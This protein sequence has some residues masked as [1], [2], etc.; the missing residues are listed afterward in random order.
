MDEYAEASLV[1]WR[2]WGPDAIEE[3]QAQGKPILLSLSARWCSWC[4]ELDETTFTRPTIAA[5]LNE[6]FVPIRVDADRQPR[7][8]ERY[9]VGGFPSVVFATSSGIPMTGATFLGPDAMRGAIASVSEVW[10]E[11]GEKAGRVPRA[12]REANTPR[13]EVTPAIVEALDQRLHESFDEAHGGWGDNAKFP[14]PR[15][16]EFA[17]VHEPDQALATLDAIATHLQDDHDG[18]FFR[19]AENADWSHPHT[20]KRL[21]ENA[22]L[23]RAFVAASRKTG[24]EAY[25]APA[26]RTVEFLTTTLWNGEAFAASQAADEDFYAHPPTGR[27][28]VDIPRVDPVALAGA[29][30][31]AIDALLDHHDASSDEGE[32]ADDPARKFAERALAHVV[33]TLVDDGEVRHY[34]DPRSE[35]SLLDDQAAVLRALTTATVVLDEAYLDTARAVAD[36]TIDTLF[37]DGA[38]VDG[39]TD[40]PALLDRTLKPL[41]GNAEIAHGLIDLARLTGESRYA[42]VARDAVGAFAGARNRLGVEAGQ[43]GLVAERVVGLEEG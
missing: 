10:D 33:E 25:L 11:E 38:F 16:N 37:D 32:Q 14:M 23:L 6:R 13:G 20:E 36:H 17:L 5:N 7:V 27:K 39:P 1:E 31:L 40:G 2:E 28:M 29:N 24:D 21:D 34:D 35:R 18:G 12:V 26:R 8:R 22:G 41:D 15:T 19:Y 4:H 30:A 9:N 3:A 43:Y 42:D